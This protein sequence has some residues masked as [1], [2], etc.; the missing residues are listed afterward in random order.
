MKELQRLRG[1]VLI[2]INYSTLYKHVEIV[3]RFK[4]KTKKQIYLC[5]F[6]YLCGLAVR[7]NQEKKVL[8]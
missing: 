7:D 6:D 8:G 2:I 3:K 1:K 4:S 5:V